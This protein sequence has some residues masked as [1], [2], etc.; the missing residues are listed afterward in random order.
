MKKP[1]KMVTIKRDTHPRFFD[2]LE[3]AREINRDN[4]ATKTLI[5][6][7][8]LGFVEIARRASSPVALARG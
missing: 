7:A 3:Q 2:A 6:A 1:L 4:T 8:T 5:E